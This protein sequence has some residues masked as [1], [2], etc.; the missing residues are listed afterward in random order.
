MSVA[1]SSRRELRRLNERDRRRFLGQLEQWNRE[2]GYY[3]APPVPADQILDYY[4]DVEPR[5]GWVLVV[6]GV[7]QQNG[8]IRETDI[9]FWNRSTRQ[10]Q[11][12]AL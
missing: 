4:F 9:P 3:G 7:E 6:V 1:P 11:S 10:S 8:I 12:R 5:R 2:F